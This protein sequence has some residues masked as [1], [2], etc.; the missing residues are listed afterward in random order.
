MDNAIEKSIIIESNRINP[1]PGEEFVG[2]LLRR[3]VSSK[4]WRAFVYAKKGIFLEEF[5]PACNRLSDFPREIIDLTGVVVDD[6]SAISGL[7]KNEQQRAFK[8]T[9]RNGKV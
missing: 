2:A 3:E 5:R 7:T 4:K 1:H 9:S 6:Q 8:V